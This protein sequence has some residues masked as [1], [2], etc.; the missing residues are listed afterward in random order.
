MD[1]Y[2]NLVDSPLGEPQYH[3]LY[4]HV[5]HRL[6]DW[7][8]LS[9]KALVFDD[10]IQA[11]DSDQEEEAVAE[12]RDQYYWLR[13]DL[14]APDGLGGRVLASHTL[15]ESSRAG[16]ADLPGISSGELD[17]ERHFTIDTLQAD[18][19]WRSARIRSYRPAPSGS[20][21]TGAMTIRIR[22]IRPAVPDARRVMDPRSRAISL[23]P[24]GHQAGAYVNWR[25][26]PGAAFAA[27]SACAGITEP[28]GTGLI[29]MEPADR[30]DVASDLSTR[31][32]V[33][34]GRYYQAQ[35]INELQVPDGKT[36][37]QRAQLATH[38][39]ASIERTS[40]RRDPARG[41]LSQ[42]LR[43]PLYATK[44]CELGVRAAGAEAGPHPHRA[45]P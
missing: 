26:E 31:L 43:P 30:P 11:F 34:W 5:G 28:C 21:R 18:G 14:G 12:Y 13:A 41:A 19:W 15:I 17:D 8:A 6:N 24:S 4:G 35:G 36:A 29:A 3:D 2:F 27:I 40:R 37:Y 38:H 32:R 1:L 33:G 7:F 39:V 44:T 23:R 20:S 16:T 9:A 42:G 25:F 45:D 22:P 10:R